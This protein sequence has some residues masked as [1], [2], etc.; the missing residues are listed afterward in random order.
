MELVK[1]IDLIKAYGSGDK[2]KMVLN[3]INFSV[4]EGEVVGFLA[5]S[6]SGKSTL[7]HLLAGLDKTTSG[8]VVINNTEITSLLLDEATEF[9]R[10][11]IGVLY[12][13]YNL[14]PSLTAEQNIT[15]PVLL[16]GSVLDVKTYADI[17]SFLKLNNLQNRYPK[18]LTGFEQ[19]CVALARALMIKPKLILCDEPT[20][21]LSTTETEDFLKILKAAK[22]KYNVTIIIFSASRKPFVFCD[23]VYRLIDGKIE[24]GGI[25]NEK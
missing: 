2:T 23:K 5:E 17:I 25:K 7:M 10:K 20:G 13:F 21:N 11:N 6:G 16:D 24:S 4:N 9:R 3:K 15:F 1:V 19:Q 22:E 14:V 12:Q 18:Q 8:K